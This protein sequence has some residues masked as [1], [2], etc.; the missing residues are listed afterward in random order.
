MPA[1]ANPEVTVTL[2]SDRE[3]TFTS[4]LDQPRH[5]VFD[6]WTMPEHVRQ[7]WGCEGSTVIFC[8]IDLRVGGAWRIVLR[9]PDGNEPRFKGEYREVQPNERLVY[10]ECFDEPT[11]GSPEW[12][13]TVAFEELDGKTR[14]THT[15]KHK[16]AGA[17]DGHLQAGMEAGT[18]HSI[19]RLAE[20][21]AHIGETG[22]ADIGVA[23]TEAV[24]QEK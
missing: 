15:V 10:T 23:E 18:K 22:A 4:I 1:N 20:R 14:L 19:R 21:A 13:T 2:P 12:L 5:R 7:W 17:R 9:L 6:A 11:F 3:I 8:E 16:T 24:L